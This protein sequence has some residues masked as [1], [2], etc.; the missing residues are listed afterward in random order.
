MALNLIGIG[1]DNEKDITV[2]GLELVRRSKK[3]YLEIYTSK[4]SCSVK[5]LE[6]FYSKKIIESSRTMIENKLDS[7]LDEAKKDEISLLIIGDVFSATTHIDI[8]LRAKEKKI[9]VNVVNNASI[10]TA[11]GVTGLE[12]YKFGRIISIP[13]DNKNLD[14]PYQ[15][16]LENQKLGLH[17]L[18]LL[19]IKPNRLM[20]VNEAVSYLI[21][22][23]FDKNTMV[24]GCAALGSS[25]P[26]IK[27][28]KAS[29]LKLK[30]YPQCLIIPGKLHFKEEEALNLYK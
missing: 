6:K 26:E 13:L 9:K 7:I 11:V 25:S 21:E 16:F 24:V 19:D 4:L 28:C 18:F 10:L 15:Y 5:D 23:G 8:L 1:L 30:K 27:Y 3:I 22:K 17:S 14:S 2:K 20:A 29:E 12:L